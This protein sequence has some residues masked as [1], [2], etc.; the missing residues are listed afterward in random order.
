[1]LN[2][3]IYIY[4]MLNNNLSIMP[5][6]LSELI[7]KSSERKM[8]IQGEFSLTNSVELKLKRHKKRKVYFI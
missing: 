1:M 8:H 5:D 3:Y 7:S 4:I 2:I 6:I